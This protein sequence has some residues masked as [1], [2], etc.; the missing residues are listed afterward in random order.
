[1]TR[2][3][4]KR[5]KR[6]EL[7]TQNKET[8]AKPIQKVSNSF[9][10]N[11]IHDSN[12]TALKTIWY[13]S[14]ILEDFD[15]TKDMLTVS[16]DLRK[17]LNYTNLNAQDIRQNFKKMQKTSITFINEEEEWEEYISLIP[18]IEF[19]WGKNSI[20]IDIYSKIAKLIIDVKKHYTFINTHELMKLKKKHSL[21][22]LP[23]LNKLKAENKTHENYHLDELNEQFGTNYKKLSDI[24]RYILTPAKE[25]LAQHKFIPFKHE[26]NFDN[27]GQGR[28]KAISIKIKLL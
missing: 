24:E 12:V 22:L 11:V 14:S 21:R 10:E 8:K 28:P 26:I 19:L 17:M 20:N 9:I 13:L 27:L 16:I 3:E 23:L 7:E 2:A 25:E 15:T 1:M 4:W 6:E 5:K 18:R